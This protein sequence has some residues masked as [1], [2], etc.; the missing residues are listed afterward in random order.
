MAESTQYIVKEGARWDTI[1]FKAY[2]R[3]SLM[4]P[5]IEANPK[6]PITPR[7]AAGTVLTIPVI[8]EIEV[9]TD[10]ELLPP[11]KR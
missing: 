2:G 10:K 7:I 3:A 8:E 6:V 5:I 9:K 11:W 1:S 4:Q